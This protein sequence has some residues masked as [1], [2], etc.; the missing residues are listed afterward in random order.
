M[1]GLIRLYNSMSRGIEDFF[2]EDRV[3]V[4]MYVCG[5]TVYDTPHLGNAR[6]AVVFDVLA[7]LLG[8]VYG[9]EQVRYARNI[10]D[11]DDKI[12]A[13]AAE[14]GV[15]IDVVTNETIAEYHAIMDLLEVTQPSFEPRATDYI[16]DM[17]DM[18]VDLI[19][20]G[21]AYVGGGDI[22]FDVASNPKHGILTGHKQEDLE[23]GHRIAVSEHK[24]NPGDFVL[25]KSVFDETQPGYDSP[26]GHGRPGWH[27]E[28]SAMIKKTLGKTI[29]I[30]GGGADLR[31][32]H[33][34]C[35]ISQ[36]CCA[37]DTDHLARYWM[38][39]GMVLVNGTKMSKSLGNFVTVRDAIAQGY[40]PQTIR[41][42]LLSTQYRSPLDYTATNLVTAA[43][44]IS[45]WHRA[46]DGIDAAP[47]YNEYA[48]GTLN[49]L[50]DDLNTPLAITRLHAAMTNLGEAPERVAAGVRYAA[51]IL[52]IDLTDNDFYLRGPK[53]EQ[54]MLVEQIIAMRNEARDNRDWAKS[55]DYRKHLTEIGVNIED[56][57]GVSTWRR[58]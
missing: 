15:S 10:T 43:Q 21:H 17:I 6:P 27:I 24:R 38:H 50:K 5:P 9:P 45:Q 33:H 46:L 11:I 42:W 13:K 4:T 57:G 36:S 30:H 58:I 22:Y 14:R 26:W 25:W 48:V 3:A 32:P 23:A 1:T 44:T 19:G 28:C 47:E 35:E 55:D 18:I 34:D 2:P 53:D 12:I 49:A 51:S 31:F 7:H 16:R 52:G 40:S 54:R 20:K 8:H 29:D 37:N 56:R 39:N 41:L